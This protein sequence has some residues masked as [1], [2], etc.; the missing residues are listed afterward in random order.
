[1]IIRH[2]HRELAHERVSTVTGDE[3]NDSHYRWQ[4]K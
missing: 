1:M 2:T 3:T 4:G